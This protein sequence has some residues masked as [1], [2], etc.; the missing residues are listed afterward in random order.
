[1]TYYFIMQSA[2]VCS[3]MIESESFSVLSSSLPTSWTIASKLLCPWNYSGKNTDVES[4]SLLQGIFPSQG[5][6]VAFQTPLSMEFFRQEYWNGQP[7]PFLGD[8][9]NPVI[10]LGSPALQLDSLQAELPGKPLY[11]CE[12]VFCHSEVRLLSTSNFLYSSLFKN[13]VS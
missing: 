6:T 8:L 10:E 9:P 1:M 2:S 11:L 13:T 7:I 5:S 3:F 4:C 12:T